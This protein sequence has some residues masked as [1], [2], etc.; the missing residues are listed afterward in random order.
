MIFTSHELRCDIRTMAKERDSNFDKYPDPRP[1]FPHWNHA[2]QDS[3][4]SKHEPKERTV[5]FTI[6]M[7]ALAPD[8]DLLVQPCSRTLRVGDRICFI[9]KSSL[10]HELPLF[11]ALPLGTSSILPPTP[12]PVCSTKMSLLPYFRESL[13][14]NSPSA[15][16]CQVPALAA[17]LAVPCSQ[18][19][20]RSTAEVAE[21]HRRKHLLAC[22]LARWYSPIKLALVV[23]LLVCWF[24]GSSLRWCV[25]VWW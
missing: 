14:P 16:L 5:Q 2:T 8:R 19:L 24:V 3:K 6:A 10:F 7:I 15:A 23:G 4:V 21:K 22:L 12:V 18:L 20:G 11:F 25:G 9:S 13:A 17:Q 1:S